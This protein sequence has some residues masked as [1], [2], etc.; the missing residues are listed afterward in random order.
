MAD[1]TISQLDTCVTNTISDATVVE[2][3]IVGGAAPESRKATIAQL[4]EVLNT[5]T[6]QVS[7]HQVGAKAGAT[8]GF[9]V[10][11]ADDLGLAATL[12]AAQTG[13]TLVIPISGLKV[14]ATIT[15]F[16]VN[17]SLQSGGNANS[18]TADLRKLTAAAAGAVD[19]SVGAMA[20]PLSVTADTVVSSANAG[21]TGL[22]EVVAEDE[23]YY[24]LITSTT[25]A[26]CTQEIQNVAITVTEV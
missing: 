10:N 13:A 4:R 7:L 1:K 9:V 14:G 26:A 6:G 15:A 23:S 18:L 5:R 20:A 19:S 12:P 3:Q 16:A 21:K 22:A 11:A 17:G 24:L 25:G 2:I 8:A